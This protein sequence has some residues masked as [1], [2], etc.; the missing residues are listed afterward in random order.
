[1]GHRDGDAHRTCRRGGQARWELGEPWSASGSHWE[2]VGMSYIHVLRAS[3]HRLLKVFAVFI[4]ICIFDKS[5]HQGILL[6]G[7]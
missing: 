1:M 7:L 2:W 4:P 3:G 5:F 6:L